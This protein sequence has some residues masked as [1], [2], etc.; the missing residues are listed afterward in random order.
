MSSTPL[1][2]I[3]DALHA[4]VVASSTYAPDKVLWAS[5]DMPRPLDDYLL[6]KMGD[7]TTDGAFDAVED[8]TDLTRPAGQEVEL[9]VEGWREFTLT[10]QAFTH[11]T[12]GPTTATEVL[13]RVQL[14]LGLPSI[15]EAL[16]AAAN[17]GPSFD[18]GTVS[19]V[20]QILGTSRFEARGTVDIGFYREVEASDYIG[21]VAEVQGAGTI[22]GVKGSGLVDFDADAG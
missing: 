2:V 3:E 16:A 14:A 15:R 17:L 4:W 10:L 7:Q 6:L 5:Q 13:T 11:A 19:S 1:D 9:R 20:P 8:F 21:Y 18:R 22:T 12:Q